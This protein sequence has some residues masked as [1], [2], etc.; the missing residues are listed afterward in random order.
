MTLN[1]IKKLIA[2]V[3]ATYP[4]FYRSFDADMGRNLVGAWNAALQR[5]AFDLYEIVHKATHRF[6]AVLSLILSIVEI[7]FSV[8]LILYASKHHALTHIYLLIPELVVNGFSP[9][10]FEIH[11]KRRKKKTEESEQK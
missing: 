9:I 7:V 6:P 3:T 4:T 5:E 2:V 8:L 11:K 1:E 10:I